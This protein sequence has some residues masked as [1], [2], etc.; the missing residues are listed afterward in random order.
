[1]DH[2]QAFS[3]CPDK[4]LPVRNWI[5]LPQGAISPKKGLNKFEGYDLNQLEIND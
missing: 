5:F 1:M 3:C 2:K 4:N